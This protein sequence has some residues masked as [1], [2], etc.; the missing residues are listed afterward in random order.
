MTSIGCM[1][2]FSNI[3]NMSAF[4]RISMPTDYY[5][6]SSNKNS[7]EW[8]SKPIR[9]TPTHK[10]STKIEPT[11]HSLSDTYKS[12]Q[13]DV[14]SSRAWTEK[15]T[16]YVLLKYFYWKYTEPSSMSLHE[17]YKTIAASVALDMGIH[18]TSTQ[19]RD[20]INNV[21]SGYKKD[22]KLGIE[23]SLKHVSP[24]LFAVMKKYFDVNSIKLYTDIH[25]E[26][27]NDIALL[28]H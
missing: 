27:D 4:R 28:L 18:K 3:H 24:S 15:A 11:T 10:K 17:M 12:V 6:I 20:K 19:I 1:S 7:P 22:S 21:K 2:H 13:D 14:M 23:S 5:V 26:I 25:E 8:H 9:S 16:K